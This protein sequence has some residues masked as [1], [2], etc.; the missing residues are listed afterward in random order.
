MVLGKK[1]LVLSA[2]LGNFDSPKEHCEQELFDDVDLIEY[3][4]Y[5]D[6]DFPPRTASMKPRLQARIPKMMGWQMKPDYDYYIW[7][8]SSCRL[9]KPDSAKWFIDKL[10]DRDI[11]FF[12]HP[13]RDTVQ[14]EADYLKYRLSI[15][16][17]YITPRYKNE[18]IDDQLAIVDPD[19]Q[20]FATTAFV[21]KNTLPARD[22]LTLWWLHTSLYH[23]IDQLSVAK[24][25]DDANARF[26][27]IPDNYQKCEYLEFTR[28]KGHK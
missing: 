13:N 19:S 8:D 11:A 20:L 7:V 9:S 28:K 6:S 27:V 18:R 26:N 24:A 2:N 5:T 3:H 17:P 4:R 22:A 12:K 1:L 21:Y 10:E 16:C 15:N 14:E 23:S 25:L